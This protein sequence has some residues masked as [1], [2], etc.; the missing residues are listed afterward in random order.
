MGS[1]IDSINISEKFNGLFKQKLYFVDK[2][3]IINK[4]NKLIEKEGALDV[5][6]TKPRRFGKTSIAAMLVSYYSKGIDSKTIFD[7]LNVSKGVSFKENEKEKIKKEIEAILKIEKK[8]KLAIVMEEKDIE[9]D[10]KEIKER[11]ETEISERVKIEIKQYEEYQGKYHTLYFDFSRNVDCFKTLVEYLA[12]INL[13]LK[14]DIEDFYPNSKVLKRY[15]NEIDSNLEKLYMETKEKFIIII[16]E[17]DYI[18]NS[19]KFTYQE[20]NAYIS[21]LKDLI[22][23]KGYA[24][25]VYMTGIL[26]IAKQLSQSTLNCF[27]EYSMLEDNEYYEYF[28]F[29]E[30]EVKD[31]CKRNIILDYKKIE[32]WY[33]GYKAYNGEK[34][35]NSWSVY[36]ALRK[37]AIK[38]YWTDTGRFDELVN[39]IN[40]KINGVEDE[41][42]EL[43]KEKEISIELEKYGAEDIQK[44]SED[45]QKKSKSKNKKSKNFQEKTEENKKE[46]DNMKIKLYSKMV[47]YGFLT[48][49]NGKISIPNKELME[50]F[51]EALDKKNGNGYYKNMKN[52]SD[53]MLKDTLNKDIEKMCLNLKNAHRIKIKVTD[54][55]DHANLKHVIDY[56]Y[57]SAH[58]NYD[59]KEEEPNGNGIPNFIFFPKNKKETVIVLEVKLNSSAKAAIKQIHQKEYHHGLL[60]KGYEGNVLLIGINC[61][62]NRRNYTC[63]IE[64]YDCNLNFLFEYPDKSTSSSKSEKIRKK[65]PESEDGIYKRL[66]SSKK[67][68]NK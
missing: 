63:I 33:D 34:I 55:V 13:K 60:E 10:E 1:V 57:F 42:L 53:E 40:F 30:Q 54:K 24:A 37:K 51:K 41:I 47:T 12:S 36:H 21:F 44:E 28:G 56:A 38:N 4:F 39:V 22:K 15:T 25:F 3:N 50:K 58:I 35:F 61:S 62:S 5:C 31:L 17:W 64:E 11:L 59:V 45:L 32:N 23:D 9:R 7:Q 43:I 16:D 66:R 8:E 27:D 26:P 20:R 46:N 14:E 68:L 49:C 65:G 48:Y 67:K 2:S 29:T 6:I 52:L 18:I 19:K